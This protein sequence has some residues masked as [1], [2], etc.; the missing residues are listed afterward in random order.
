VLN[1][2]S[3]S[4][5]KSSTATSNQGNSPPSF[6]KTAGLFQL[7]HGNVQ[8]QGKN[9]N[10]ST[11]PKHTNQ[12][13]AQPQKSTS[14]KVPP[15]EKK[16]QP[17][18]KNSPPTPTPSLQIEGDHVI[19]TQPPSNSGNILGM[20]INPGVMTP[21]MLPP[22]VMPVSG[23]NYYGNY[24][25]PGSGYYLGGYEHY[26]H[27]R[28]VE[29]PLMGPITI[30]LPSDN[31][32]F[33]ILRT[34]SGEIQLNISSN[35]QIIVS[36]KGRSDESTTEK[37]RPT[38][39]DTEENSKEGEKIEKIDKEKTSGEK[40]EPYLPPYGM[41]PF[42]GYYPY[43]G[44]PEINPY[45]YPN[46]N[47]INNNPNN[48]NSNN[49]GN[50]AHSAF[51]NFEGAQA[52]FAEYMPFYERVSIKPGDVVLLNEGKISTLGF[53]KDRVIPRII[54]TNPLILGNSPKSLESMHQNNNKHAIIAMMGQ[55]PVNLRNDVIANPGDFIVAGNSFGDVYTLSPEE[56]SLKWELFGRIVGIALE[57]SCFHGSQINQVPA[58]IFYTDISVIVS[59]LN[60]EIVRGQSMFKEVERR[61]KRLE[62]ENGLIL[63]RI[64]YLESLVV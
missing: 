38:K 29:R 63:K 22:G 11:N 25:Y 4:P 52:D 15:K 24:H 50:S 44:N 45:Y 26:Y 39:K 56:M 2:T 41:M 1:R 61:V 46:Y 42:P 14:S 62:E 35:N 59:A 12:D 28:Q 47:F 53:D 9:S 31:V 43:P 6:P 51:S 13:S 60:K 37:E 40:G 3:N 49:N 54:S 10:S 30:E 7:N 64:R 36:R 21:N 16:S 23:A 34:P 58:L 17:A 19:S 33:L 5:P 18:N 8:F 55:V 48:N 27:W 57:H 32:P 20:P